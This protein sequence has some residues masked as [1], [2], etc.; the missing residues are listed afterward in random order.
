M[1]GDEEKVVEIQRSV[2]DVV[3]HPHA[4]THTQRLYLNNRKM[5]RYKV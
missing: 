4:H 2:D 5:F 1:I 3:E